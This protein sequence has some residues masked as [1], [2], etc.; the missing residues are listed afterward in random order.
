MYR[1]KAK[2]K[3]LEKNYTLVRKGSGDGG[4]I[5]NFK[6]KSQAENYA[7]Q[8]TSFDTKIVKK[9]AKPR[10]RLINMNFF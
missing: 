3:K 8:L 7:N 9:K 2:H 6:T 4:G 10:K 5:R 1:V